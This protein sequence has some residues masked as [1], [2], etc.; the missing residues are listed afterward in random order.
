MLTPGQR[1]ARIVPDVSGIDKAFD[2][3][4]P[5]SIDELIDV[6]SIVRVELNGRRVGGWV[7]EIDVE[8]PAGV[9]LREI[10][11]FSSVG[12][13]AE[14]VELADWA[15]HRWAGRLASILRTASPDRMTRQLPRA[16]DGPDP[17]LT[18][19]PID[20][21]GSFNEAGVTVVRL[22]P[23]VDLH[24]YVVAAAS[25]GDAVIVAPSLADARHH[26]A[27]LRRA[28]GR[29]YLAGRDFVQAATA[30]SVIG[31]RSAVW[32]SVRKLAVV[33]V[34]DEH[35]ESLQ[36]ERNPTWHARDVA[37]ERA[38]RAGVP[39]VLISPAPSIAAVKVA[40]RIVA[41]SRSEERAGW[42][43][44]QV[45][46]SRSGDPV[47]SSLFSSELVD[48]VRSDLKVLCI[49]NRK[50]RA[51]MLACAS[52]G[53]LARTLDGEHLM[54]EFEGRLQHNGTGESRPLV[55]ANC[56]ATKLKRLQLGVNRAAEEL[57]A[58][59]G[60]DVG[61]VTADSDAAD[62]PND[63]VLVGTEAL[64]HRSRQAGA[65][66]FLD[67]DQ[68]L[69]APRYRAGEQAMALLVRAARLVG[70]RE[71][72][73]R[74]LIQT[75]TPNH[76]VLTSVLRADPSRFIDEE[77]KVRR[78]TGFPPFGALAEISGAPSEAFVDPLRNRLD[79]TVL[80]PRADGH[81]L[82][83]ADTADHLADV[84][85]DADRPRGRLRVAVDP[86]RV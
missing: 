64:L 7:K 53:D 21:A 17:L 1:V 19:A 48:L 14:I 69:L 74:L 42:P 66:A 65:V 62:I 33:L 57:A 24:P 18:E 75:R 77:T 67:F 60:E 70:G 51:R 13:S 38:M 56:G 45:V 68:E 16:P 50:G 27:A 80:G 9:S 47:R 5:T 3:S 20:V 35:D 82:L 84:L 26:G 83:R 32:A 52:C 28:G 54:T 29:V 49:L 55:C 79:V 2:Y 43:T 78:L 72:G 76:R 39:C 85:A 34:I 37:V 71:E 40:E 15:A 46:D 59:V 41:P 36:E 81:Y 61:D 63:R 25:L 30:G 8:P 4:V 73:G 58:L 10:V 12:P 22:A 44:T 31:A 86:P 6:G 11:K 23:G